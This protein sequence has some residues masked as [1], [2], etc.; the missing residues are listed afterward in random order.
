MCEV[1][2]TTDGRG[3]GVRASRFIRR[4]EFVCAYHGE[5][6]RGAEEVADRERLY[7]HLDEN[8]SLVFLFKLKGS[9]YAID[10]TRSTHASRFIN[11]SRRKQNIKPRAELRGVTPAIHFYASKHIAPGEEILFDYGDRRKKVLE[12]FPWLKE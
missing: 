10:A 12:A 1:F 8:T 7:D 6:L 9:R 4:G 11:H 2:K 5:L 3:F